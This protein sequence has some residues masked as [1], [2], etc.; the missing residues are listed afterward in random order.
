MVDAKRFVDFHS[1]ILPGADHGSDSLAISLYQLNSAKKYGI[2]KIVSTSHF[3]PT[4]HSVDGFLKRRNE[5]YYELIKERLDIP[6]IR[7]GAEVLLCN[8]IDHLEGIEKLCINGTNTLLLELPFSD[9]RDDYTQTVER[10]LQKD[11]NVVL[12]H[13]DR[14]PHRVIETL[15]PLG[16]K[17]Q[18]NAS[19]VVGFNR[20][21]NSHLF[22]WMSRGV[23]LAFG[24]DIHGRDSGAYHRLRK[25]FAS[26]GDFS[27]FITEQSI[28]IWNQAVKFTQIEEHKV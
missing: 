13:A 15:I 6:D 14:Y 20:L 2:T 22:D 24:S 18:L 12:A 16:V 7:L 28:K 9:Y 27:E 10:L 4:A 8:G 26:A 1:H 25:A 11:L 5:A 3:Y 21:K 19:A 17:L 23:V